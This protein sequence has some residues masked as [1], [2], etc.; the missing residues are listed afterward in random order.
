MMMID[1]DIVTHLEAGT[2]FFDGYYTYT[3][4]HEVTTNTIK[5][6]F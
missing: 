4:T 3:H 1:I 2:P 5:T 6:G